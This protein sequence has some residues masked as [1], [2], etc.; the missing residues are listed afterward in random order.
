MNK[1]AVVDGIT[2]PDYSKD[3]NVK[4]RLRAG[5]RS[6]NVNAGR[7]ADFP[8]DDNPAVAEERQKEAQELQPDEPVPATEGDI[9]GFE[10]GGIVAEA[11]KEKEATETPEE[12]ATETPEE[13]ATEAPAVEAPAEEA[14]T[15]G[16]APAAKPPVGDYTPPEGA[17]H[18]DLIDQYHDALAYGDMEQ[19]KQLY[20]Q[21][22]EHRFQ[23]NTHRTK[24]EAQ[25]QQDE[26]SYLQAAEEL[27]QA[28]PE[29]GQ[30]GIDADKVMALS[31]VYR[32]NGMGAAEA[33]RQ[34]VADLY[35]EQ[36]TEAP[37]VEAPAEEADMKA[38]A[39]ETP[40]APA[41]EAPAEEA[42]MKARKIS[43]KNIPALPSAS[44]RNEPPPP[45]KQPTRSDA[46]AQMK[47]KRGQA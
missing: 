17:S 39:V 13:E 47:A 33:L 28:H 40:E 3:E 12:E 1:K 8:V 36:A 45:P 21:L 41:V 44:A 34:A 22:Q 23:E 30:D 27:V 11:E 18:E 10:D 19:A 16:S 29:L 2:K 38:P 9:Q 43:K 7:G 14:T 42:D 46:I 25:A 35:K 5:R 37:A 26:D 6:S 20:K 31:D 4:A 24:S 32:N 15:E